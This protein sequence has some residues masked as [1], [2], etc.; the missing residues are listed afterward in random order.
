MKM[1]K[2]SGLSTQPCGTPKSTPIQEEYSAESTVRMRRLERKE[3][4]H[5]QGL[6][7]TPAACR[8]SSKM[9]WSTRSKAFWMSRK[10]TGHWSF[11]FFFPDPACVLMTDCRA[12][13][14]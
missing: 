4:I 5:N 13:Y 1:R 3:R 2:R 14:R 6:P 12:V 7:V 9:M 10:R 8:R 11:A